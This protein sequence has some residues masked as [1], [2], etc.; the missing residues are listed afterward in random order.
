[1]EQQANSFLATEPVGR[2][3]QK[4]A[5]PCVISLLI[6]A[7]YNVTDQ[8]FIGWGVGMLGNGATNVVFP[9]T[10]IVLAVATMIGDGACTFVSISLGRQDRD[11]AGRS[12]GN[13][14]VLSAAAGVLISAVYALFQTDILYLFAATQSNFGYAQEYLTYITPG[15]PFYLFGQAM[16]PIIRSDGSPRFAMFSTLAGALIN[17]VLDPVAIFWLGWGM[18]GAALATIA[19]QIVT[20]LLAV[21]YLFR[22]KTVDLSLPAFTLR[23][24]L[25]ARFLPLG[26]CSLLSQGSMVVAQAVTN[27]MC[28]RY[29]ALS[30][31]GADIP[32]TV[33]GIV[34]KFLQ[35]VIAVSIGLA[36]G[37]IPIV[38]YNFGARRFDRARQIMGRLLAAETAVGLAAFVVIQLFPRQL[39]ALFGSGDQLYVQF[40]VRAFRV[41]LGMIVLACINKGSFIFMQS[42]GRPVE[43]T[44][45]SLFREVILAVPL[46]ILLPRRLG[47]D[48]VLYSMPLSDLI[49][50][51]AS[52]LIVARTNRH[53]RE[54]ERLAERE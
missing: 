8:I 7:V 34:C 42:L 27:Q 44:L 46:V 22:M 14:V 6:G 36:A 52:V 45:L 19:G 38:G 49:A 47:L 5:V 3:M 29:G 26:F 17:V 54:A 15:I 11:S 23:G 9:L 48:G 28:V 25:I 13:A 35:I 10:V 32:L 12:V 21:F 33:L 51:A 30:E 43:S 39:I 53:L 40:A 18:R 24:G 2:L 16:N 50:F 41:Y 20:A 31:Y 1:M 4:F 37:C